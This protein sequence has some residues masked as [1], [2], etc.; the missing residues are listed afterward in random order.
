MDICEAYGADWIFGSW[1]ALELDW[2]KAVYVAADNAEP[3]EAV[4]PASTAPRVKHDYAVIAAAEQKAHQAKLEH[5][6][7]A[8]DL[9]ATFQLFHVLLN[10]ATKQH[11]QMMLDKA[12]SLLSIA[13]AG[14]HPQAMAMVVAWPRL[15]AEVERKFP[16]SG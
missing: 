16:R 4:V 12:G 6:A 9:E 13:A 8:G 10:A 3:V 2:C 15:K 1:S 7:A 14:G 5:R 11:S